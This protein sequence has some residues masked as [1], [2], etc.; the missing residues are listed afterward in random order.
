MIQIG[1][2]VAARSRSLVLLH[3]LAASREYD[4]VHERSITCLDGGL[5]IVDDWLRADT[6][7]E[8]AQHFQLGPAAQG[9]TRLVAGEDPARLD[10][11]GLLLVRGMPI[12]NPCRPC[13]P[14]LPEALRESGIPSWVSLQSCT[15]W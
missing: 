13:R 12:N 6:A 9:Q 8:Y 7:H 2:R 15:R 5:W 10:S 11:P 1:R 3:G 4:A 14:C